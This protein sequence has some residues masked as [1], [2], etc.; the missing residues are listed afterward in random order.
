MFEA[1]EFIF[2]VKDDGRGFD[3]AQNGSSAAS[4]GGNGLL[5]M[6]R[7]AESLGGS[8]RIESKV[9][10]GTLSILRVPLKQKFKLA[11]FLSK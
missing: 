1:D 7:R 8:Y 10:A 9:G 6:K 4:R 3:V 2:K 11:T 5:N